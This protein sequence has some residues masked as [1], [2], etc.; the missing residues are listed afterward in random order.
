MFITIIITD[1]HLHE[2]TQ[3]QHQLLHFGIL[4]ILFSVIDIMRNI[5]VNHKHNQ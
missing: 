5:M 4:I 1:G 3:P 2:S